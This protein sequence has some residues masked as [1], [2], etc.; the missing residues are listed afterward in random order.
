MT[1]EFAAQFSW[2]TLIR[3]SRHFCRGSGFC[4]LS[5]GKRILL[6]IRTWVEE[7][8]LFP[9][10][11]G[12]AEKPAQWGTVSWTPPS[13]VSLVT[14]YRLGLPSCHGYESSSVFMDP[15]SP[16]KL[17]VGKFVK[18]PFFYHF[19]LYHLSPFHHVPAKLI[20]LHPRMISQNGNEVKL[21]GVFGQ[22]VYLCEGSLCSSR[23]QLGS[24]VAVG[25]NQAMG[26]MEEVK[27]MPSHSH[28]TFVT[29][30]HQIAHFGRES[31]KW[32]MHS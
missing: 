23:A 13:D 6:S 15:D 17:I 5:V 4:Y 29:R 9:C 7:L 28:P 16:Q 8:S 12:D 25:T 19:L 2:A 14:G 21:Q 10:Q 27:A 11:K 30:G 18:V 26:W 32:E 20:R 3:S 1:V 24:H 31:N 22:G